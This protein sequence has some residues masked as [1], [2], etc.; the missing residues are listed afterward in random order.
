MTTFRKIAA[1]VCALSVAAAPSFGQSAP[2]PAN[3]NGRIPI[4]EYHLIGDTE[5]RWEVEREHFRRNLQL[6]YDRGYRPVSISE[7]VS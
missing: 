7:L 4:L 6:L 2:R 5:G 3:T 1:A